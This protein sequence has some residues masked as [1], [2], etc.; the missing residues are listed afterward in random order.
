MKYLFSIF[1]FF[2]ISQTAIAQIEK[3][4]FLLD[5]GV[6][7]G[8]H[9]EGSFTNTYFS[10]QQDIGYMLNN[11]IMVGGGYTL[12]TSFYFQEKLTGINSLFRYYLMNKEKK[13]WFISNRVALFGN[14]YSIDTG[15]GLSYSLSPSILWESKATY[16]HQPSFAGYDYSSFIVGS[17]LKFFLNKGWKK[18]NS[19]WKSVL[20]KG[21]WMIGG[22]SSKLIFGPSATQLHINPNIG[23]FLSDRW[24]IGG[25]AGVD[26]IGINNHSIKNTLVRIQPFTRYYFSPPTARTIGFIEGGLGVTYQR[27]SAEDSNITF[28]N[29]GLNPYNET[30]A[31]YFSAIGMDVF[32]SPT[33]ALEL[34][35][36][37]QKAGRNTRNTALIF[38]FQFFL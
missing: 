34:K 31:I 6:N 1:A 16:F 9:Q 27:I 21:S 29:T 3:G 2:L 14:T 12:S 23:Y 18:E 19:D 26:W 33:V 38:G 7:T 30:E 8:H 13:A 28:N 35:G 10:I 11:R 4:S 15:I 32:L 24:V 37:Y 36:Q 17:G 22:T 25:L 20:S 5:G